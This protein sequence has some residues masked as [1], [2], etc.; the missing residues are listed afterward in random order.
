MSAS[1][2]DSSCGEI[3]ILLLIFPA[4]AASARD[5]DYDQQREPEWSNFHSHRAGF[6]VTWSTAWMLN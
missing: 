6:F 1:R 3:L 2:T 5:H 4:G